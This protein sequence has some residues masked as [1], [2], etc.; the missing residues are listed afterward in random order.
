[1]DAKSKRGSPRR[2]WRQAGPA[3]ALSLHASGSFRRAAS[4]RA[5]AAL[6]WRRGLFDDRRMVRFHALSLFR[7][8]PFPGL[9]RWRKR[10]LA[11]DAR[12]LCDRLSDAAA[13]RLVLQPYR[14]PPRAAAHDAS[15]GGDDD[16]GDAR[17]RAAPDPDGDRSHGRLAAS[18]A[19]L[20]DGVLGRRRIYRRRRLFARRCAA[21]E[22]R[23]RHLVRFGGKRGR[24]AAR[25][26][27]LGADGQPDEFRRPGTLGLA[28]PLLRR[29]RA[30]R[31]GLARALDDARIAG[32]PPP[33]GGRDRPARA[34][35]LCPETPP[36]RDCPRLLHL[37]A[38]LDHL[39]CR[40]HLRPFLPHLGRCAYRAKRA[41]AVDYR[42]G[43]GDRRHAARRLVVGQARPASGAARGVRGERDPAHHDVR[44]DGEWL[45]SICLARRGA[46]R[47]RRRRR[48]RGRSGRHGRAVPRRSAHHRPRPR[49]DH[50]DRH[51]RRAHAVGGAMAGRT[52][53]L[54][55]WRRAR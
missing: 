6:A 16:R 14:R 42:R 54:D 46:P 32:V 30:R 22:A 4:R 36:R 40:D 15:V 31:R 25:G 26:R 35:S 17:D 28:H 9:L 52:H 33:A 11:A 44:A 13:R 37:R 23:A 34:A 27:S 53:R 48:Q 10:L 21:L 38:G 29:R 12:R 20:R 19:A 51:L 5:P 45:N 39:L 50:G 47:R 18:R 43:R 2:A 55:A 41:V 24:R 49:R 3:L 7:H 8:G 1:M